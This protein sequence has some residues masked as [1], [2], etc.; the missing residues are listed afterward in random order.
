MFCFLI[1]PTGWTE[2]DGEAFAPGFFI[3]N[4]EVGSRSVGIET[5]WYQSVCQNHI[6]WDAVEIVEFTRKHTANVHDAL[7][8]IRRIIEA[9]VLKR[10]ARRDTFARVIEKAMKTELGT[11]AEESPKASQPERDHPHAGQGSNLDCPGTRTTDDLFDGRCTHPHRRKDRQRGRPRGS[12]SQGRTFAGLGSVAS[13]EDESRRKSKG[14]FIPYYPYP[15]EREVF[16]SKSKKAKPVHELRLGRIKAAIWANE[17][18]NGIRHNVTLSRL[19]KPEGE[20]L[21]GFHELWTRRL[22]ACGKSRRHGPYLD[23]SKDPGAKRFR[24]GAQ[25]CSQARSGDTFLRFLRPG[26]LHHRPHP[27][28]PCYQTNSGGV[29]HT[30]G[31]SARCRWCK[32]CFV[33]VPLPCQARQFAVLAVFLLAAHAASLP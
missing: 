10:D 21:A 8:D 17:T 29:V 6:V 26:L 27:F 25:R 4:S 33:E 1:D 7:G 19:Y 15:N 28:T 2:I 18:D 30:M 31:F 12:R 11:E 16:M 14:M 32:R 9:L 13:C 5:F 3:W 23:F 22:A 20:D 24:Q